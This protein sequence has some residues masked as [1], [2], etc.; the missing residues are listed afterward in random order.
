MSYL[1]SRALVEA[2]SEANSLDGAPSVPS[3]TTPTP[4]AYLSPDRMTDFSR[5][6]RFGMTFAPLTDDLGG[7]VLTWCL[8]DSRAR[9]SASPEAA[10]ESTE[11]EADFGQKW[12][13]LFV[14]YDRD[15]HSWKTHQCLFQED[16]PWSWVTLPK[17]G[18]LRD[19]VCWGRIESEHPTKETESGLWRTPTV[20]MLNADRAKD[21]EYANRK[22]AKG[23]TITLADQ[24][25]NPRMWPTPRAFMHK[26][27]TTDRGKG[28]LG[29]VVGGQLNPTWVEWLMGWPLNWSSLET[30]RH[31]YFRDWQEKSAAGLP[32]KYVSVMRSMW[33]DEDPSETP[34]RPRSNKQ[35]P[36]KHRDPMHEL[37]RQ[38]ASPAETGN[39]P[40]L[41]S[42]VS[43]QAEAESDIVRQARML[44]ADGETISRITVGVKTRVDRLRA[45]GNGQV[46]QCAA[47]AWRLLTQ[48]WQT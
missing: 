35:Q 25:R 22:V 18:L 1:C 17:W 6:S 44:K 19:G 13:E 7:A 14:R 36:E 2:Y 32:D 10:R 33:W 48:D 45:I 16:L 47:E 30:L 24:A 46:P 34:Y 3:K 37:S 39:L 43:T 40:D 28:N 15:T 12:L 11:S 5:L 23:Q 4:Q 27:S 42:G 21:P 31:D 29:E 20:G 9:T 38:G 41:R 8:A 26:D